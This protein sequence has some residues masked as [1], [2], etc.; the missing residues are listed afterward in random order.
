MDRTGL[1]LLVLVIVHIA[2]TIAFDKFIDEPAELLSASLGFSQIGLLAIWLA[3]GQWTWPKRLGSCLIGTAILV[4]SQQML[5][6][7]EFLIP[8]VVT[9]LV[10]AAGLIVA[11]Y[12]PPKLRLIQLGD[13]VLPSTRFQFSL[14]Q[15]MALFVGVAVMLTLA[16]PIRAYAAT[17]FSTD[18]ELYEAVAETIVIL[19][20]GTMFLGCIVVG[21][22]ATWASLGLAG[23][24]IRITLALVFALTL[25]SLF[26]YCFAPLFGKEFDE[27]WYYLP[28]LLVCQSLFTMASLLVIRAGGYRLIGRKEMAT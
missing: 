15:V 27:N 16:R 2:A 7:V 9:E 26:T 12:G 8:I 23:L 10:L 5:A 14:R 11:R 13:T 17:A 28:T 21:W 25:G 1:R 20:E 18:G 6:R 22:V 19:V 3:V 4:W 24:P